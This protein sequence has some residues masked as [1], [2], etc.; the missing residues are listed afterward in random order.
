ML[1]RSSFIFGCAEDHQKYA[2]CWDGTFHD[3]SKMAFLSDRGD[4]P[5]ASWAASRLGRVGLSAIAGSFQPTQVGL[6]WLP[7]VASSLH[8]CVGFHFTGLPLPSLAG[9]API[10][11]IV[12]IV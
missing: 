7:A 12:P 8:T 6:R 9:S 1:H 10:T 2:T 11:A 3:Q 5:Y 4:P